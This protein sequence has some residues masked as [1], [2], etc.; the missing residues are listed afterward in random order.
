MKYLL[1]L[2]IVF[3]ILDGLLTHFL[4][5]NETLVEG[6]PFLQPL[7]GEAN[8]LLIKVLGGLLCALI[9]WDIYQRH[10]WLATITTSCCAM[11]YAGI[12]GWNLGLFLF[13]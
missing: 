6:N 8:F 9:L 11:F 13:V 1:G 12:V 5:R 10:P 4:L 3:E 7:V 2:L